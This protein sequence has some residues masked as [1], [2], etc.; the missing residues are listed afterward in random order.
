MS[1]KYNL[2]GI[3]L[4]NM[5]ELPTSNRNYSGKKSDDANGREKLLP[6]INHEETHN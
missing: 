1:S 2:D 3:G 6:D 4:K 5:S